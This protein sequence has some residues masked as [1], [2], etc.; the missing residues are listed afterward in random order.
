MSGRCTGCQAEP[1]SAHR[2]GCDTAT[3]AAWT[4]AVGAGAAS[5][6]L[7]EAPSL[8]PVPVAARVSRAWDVAIGQTPSTWSTPPAELSALVRY[9]QDADW[10]DPTSRGWRLAGQ[11]YAFLVAIPVSFVAYLVAW[12]VQ[13]PGRLALAAL[14]GGA[15]TLAVVLR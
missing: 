13:R 8:L 4:P 3:E 10:C 6:D 11:V 14:L 9:A 2:K 5:T 12:T 1:G 15:L 7:V